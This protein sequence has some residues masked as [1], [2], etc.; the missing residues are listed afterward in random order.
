MLTQL[1]HIVLNN[2][3]HN[4]T[5]T[6]KVLPYVKEEYFETTSGRSNFGLIHSHFS[7]YNQCPTRSEHSIAIESLSGISSDEFTEI[8][9][10]LK[11]ST[12]KQKGTRLWSF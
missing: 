8:V 5:Y 4:E 9:S 2:L 7:K 10:P 6:R 11:L 3:V 1:E 12:P